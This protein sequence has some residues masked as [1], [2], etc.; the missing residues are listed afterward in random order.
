M[1]GQDEYYRSRAATRFHCI[2]VWL[3]HRRPGY[4][5]AWL[6]LDDEA[7]PFP[8]DQRHHLVH[9]RGTLANSLV[10]AELA[11]RLALFLPSSGRC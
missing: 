5:G 7:E 6:A 11:E 8:S 2:D 1:A 10:Q 9:A 4:T 3:K